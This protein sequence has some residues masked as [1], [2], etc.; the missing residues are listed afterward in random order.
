MR[1]G[2]YVA[3]AVSLL[4]SGIWRKGVFLDLTEL[5]VCLS[6]AID[7]T[8]DLV[9][10]SVR[11]KGATAESRTQTCKGDLQNLANYKVLVLY[12]EIR[13]AIDSIR[14]W[15]SISVIKETFTDTGGVRWLKL[16]Q[17]HGMARKLHPSWSPCYRVK[18]TVL[19]SFCPFVFT[20]KGIET[21]REGSR[22][23]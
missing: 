22:L 10:L 9:Y 3:V 16:K 19:K 1:T 23:R 15:W 20:D 5:S 21:W 14:V 13:K 12:S 6:Q 8:R 2:A 18:A 17:Q 7:W 4:L 11:T